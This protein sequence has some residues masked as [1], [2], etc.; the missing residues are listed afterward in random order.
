M[1]TI[2]PLYRDRD[3]LYEHYIVLQESTYA[4]AREAGCNHETVRRWLH[5]FN[6]PIRDVF[7]SKRN[8]LDLSSELSN[9]LEGELLGVGMSVYS[10]KDFLDYIGPC[11]KEIQNCYGYKW[12]A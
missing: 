8:Y 3:W 11:P 12:E 4:M 7:E 9:L 5:K 6:I 2:Q 10:V 1:K